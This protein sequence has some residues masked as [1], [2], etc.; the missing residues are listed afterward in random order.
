MYY[1]KRPTTR[2]IRIAWAAAAALTLAA[3]GNARA[4]RPQETVR[5]VMAPFE[6]AASF[7][8]E[9]QD[10]RGLSVGLS[11]D[12]P[13]RGASSLKVSVEKL[14]GV[15]TRSCR[16]AIPRSI[17]PGARSLVLHA[18]TDCDASITPVVSGQA[19][20]L[21]AAQRLAPIQL[22]AGDGW[23]PHGIDLAPAQ[24]Q[25]GG[26]WRLEA[27]IIEAAG[28]AAGAVHLDHL[29]AV[30]PA[31]HAGARHVALYTG[32]AGNAFAETDDGQV[33]LFALVQNLGADEADLTLS[34][35]V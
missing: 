12:A 22:A 30:V 4:E 1:A 21:R 15:R 6:H 27:L 13:F 16:I 24:E 25:T 17:P 7:S 31:R 19:G 23:K 3:A 33:R 26:P 9:A 32:R 14:D 10:A 8:A 29:A 2:R 11:A 35:D 18:R 28:A 5:L 34:W 20:R